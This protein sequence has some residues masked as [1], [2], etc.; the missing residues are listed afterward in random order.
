MDYSFWGI[1]EET[2]PLAALDSMQFGHAL[3]RLLREIL[4]ASPK[5]GPVYLMKLD[6]ADGFYQ[7]DLNIQDIP[8]LGVIFPTNPGNESLVA[9]PLVL[10]MGWTNSPPIFSTATE[11][12]ADIANQRIRS[13]TNILPHRL[14]NLAHNIVPE[15]PC[16]PQQTCP[17]VPALPA[18]T[19][20]DPSLPLH[21]KKVQYVLLNGN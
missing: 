12:I 16:I 21:R 14:D 7:I 10:P 8:K 5:N 15:R 17:S 3:E 4:L 13:A 6:I 9:L 20:R 11:T 19:R 18:P 2:L 1:N